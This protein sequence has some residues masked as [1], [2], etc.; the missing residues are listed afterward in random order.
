MESQ[1]SP[2]L[3][4]DLAQI[5][6]EHPYARKLL[7]APRLGVGREVLRSLTMHAGSWIGFETATPWQLAQRIAGPR[8]AA[9][10]LRVIDAHD[11]A[12]LLDEAID[13]V[14]TGDGRLAVLAE[15]GGL[16]KSIARAVRS[17][18][19]AG[20]D[21]AALARTRFQDD[22]KRAQLS[23]ILTTYERQLD[24]GR[25][26]DTAGV[27]RFAVASLAVH[28]ADLGGAQVF[29]LP[30]QST[31][32]LPGQLLSVMTEQ[33]A[34]VLRTE[35][36]HGLERPASLLPGDQP[37]GG[38]LSSLHAVPSSHTGHST[39]DLFAA[40]S[41]QVELREVLRRVVARGLH[42]DEV[43]IV[44]TDATAYGVALDVIAQRNDI[45]VTYAAG[46]PVART[47]PG[48]AVAKYLEWVQQGYRSDTLREML[49]RGD[50]APP[51]AEDT[52][53]GMALA[54]RLR[55]MRIR[56]GRENYA[57][58]IERALARIAETTAPADDRSAAETAADHQR[59]VRETE[60]L[61][62]LVEALLSTTPH[63]ASGT[64]STEIGSLARGVIALLTLV[65]CPTSVDRTARARLQQTLE[66]IAAT[67]RR[68]TTLDAAIAFVQES[69][70][71][72]VP[73]PESAGSTPWSSTGGHLYLSD[74]DHGGYTGRAATFVV[75]LDA[76]R[77]PGSG[78]QDA[79]L[80]D[81][82]RRRL[83]EDT[84]GS[85][86]P[87]GADIVEEKRYRLALLLARL[88]GDVT[89]SYSTWDA[90]EGRAIPPA[91]E[92]LQAFRLRTGDPA[93][94]YDAM[95]R[96]LAPS[97]SPLARTALLDTDDVWLNTLAAGSRPRN[98]RVAVLAAFPG[99][100]AG[101]K[102]AHALRGPVLTPFHGAIAPRRRLDPRHN[103][104]MVVSATQLEALGACPHRYMLRNILGVRV[105]VEADAAGEG[106]LTPPER[107]ALLHQ[108]F[109]RVA[110]ELTDDPVTLASPALEQRAVD[111]LDE[112]AAAL[113]AVTPAPA[114]AVF[115]AE[116]NSMRT[117]MR[118][119]AAM[120][121]ED[122][123][124]WIETERAFGQG[125]KDTVAVTL[126][127]GP[128]SLRG[129]I[130]RIDRNEDGTLTVIDYKTGSAFRFSPSH[131]D[132]DGGRRLQHVLYAAAAE[133]LYGAEVSSA[134]YQF[135]SR[136][137]ENHRATVGR[138]VL[139]SGL[140]VIDSLL[141]LAAAGTFHPTNDRED[142]R[143]C[144]YAIVCR[145]QINEY[146]DITSQ[147]ADWS[148][149]TRDPALRTQRDLRGR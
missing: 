5:A 103:P 90:V 15:G 86:L 39:P 26:T 117:D 56:R 14:L 16:R 31:R 148:R 110:H 137:S 138:P 55:R 79:L 118:A 112:L 133:A 84:A 72:H 119:F 83:S 63:S 60:A 77:F 78:V 10:G 6:R 131:R 121:R 97:A 129:A 22:E 88:R 33:G 46:L 27:Y 141:G 66:R 105:P 13:E 44:T 11:H 85:A 58:A 114:P 35:P 134:Q 36:V 82:D 111:I 80:V 40:S 24:R 50:I 42:W 61:R 100:A 124:R 3:I 102:A 17:L 128:I 52:I 25:L 18:R 51:K 135:P 57:P 9:E 136:R 62:D 107:G 74:L 115:D 94:D 143:F 91:A 38:A 1:H 93:A 127:G 125:G 76:L 2:A 23:R 47:R 106:W 71:T 37:G 32:G 12:A 30:G 65:S 101:M 120:L 113:R 49:E 104:D 34:R 7:V 109:Q 108:A 19:L 64:E 53:S 4:V 149:E 70:D 99:L 41:V 75:G 73:A 81:D 98:G 69:V 132:F 123:G 29:L 95:H 43:E 45:P 20:I 8:I 89:L 48:R 126:D 142:C 28:E 147:R 67:S 139:R 122:G 96:A 21:G 144:D 145:V 140:K 87:S 92:M 146:G 59:D 130:D 68:S 54:R 116:L